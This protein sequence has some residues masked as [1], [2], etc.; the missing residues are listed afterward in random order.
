[1]TFTAKAATSGNSRALRLDAALFKSHPEFAKGEFAVHV[2]GP[3]TMLVTATNPASAAD[4][5]DPVLTAYLAFLDNQMK[6]R[7]DLIR[8]LTGA[9]VA[10][11][12]QLLAGVVVNRDE[13]LGDFEL[14]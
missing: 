4:E 12:D 14:P 5:Q 10:G 11:L 6:A 8:P 13:D 1:M 3:G 9:H 2:L 7:P